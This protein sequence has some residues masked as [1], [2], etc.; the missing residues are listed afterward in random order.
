MI[1]DCNTSWQMYKIKRQ[2]PT[3][4]RRQ[5]ISKQ[6]TIANARDSRING[7]CVEENEEKDSSI[8]RV[9]IH[10]R[11][12]WLISFA[13]CHCCGST[14]Y[15]FRMKTSYNLA[16]EKLLLQFIWFVCSL[17]NQFLF[18]INFQI[19]QTTR[20]KR[21][22][23]EN[24]TAN[25]GNKWHQTDLRAVECKKKLETKRWKK[26]LESLASELQNDEYIKWIRPNES[27]R[28][29]ISVIV[30][31]MVEHFLFGKLLSQRKV[32]AQH[33]SSGYGFGRVAEN[34]GS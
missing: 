2:P 5:R 24:W 22:R 16:H 18:Q 10:I 9:R 12:K 29:R 14:L 30:I 4:R 33:Y 27:G 28:R 7:N 26:P 32:S 17:T 23:Q 8:V 15:L 6:C 31:S 1:N 11:L 19:Q 3:R 25:E 20:R 21:Q 34:R 13:R